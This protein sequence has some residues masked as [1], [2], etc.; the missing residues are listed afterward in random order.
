MPKGYFLSAHRAEANEEKK[1]LTTI[2]PERRW[3]VLVAL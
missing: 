2:W 3:K 1:Q